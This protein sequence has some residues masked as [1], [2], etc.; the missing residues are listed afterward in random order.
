MSNVDIVRAVAHAQLD[1]R[2]DDMVAL[3]H[4][5]IVWRPITRR[6]GR[7]MY[8]GHDGVRQMLSDAHAE[9]G[10]FRMEWDDFSEPGQ[11]Q[12]VAGGAFVVEVD[13]VETRRRFKASCE[14][15]DR[16]VWRVEITDDPA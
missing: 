12:V 3:M 1:G 10:D 16:L 11:D 5:D 8:G 7:Y 14:L 4:P 2:I 15:R 9:A 6:G 13:G